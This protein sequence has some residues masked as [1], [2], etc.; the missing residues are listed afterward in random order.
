MHVLAMDN[1]P[2][3]LGKMA[4]QLALE[5]I[6]I[7]YVYGSAMDDAERSIFVFHVDENDWERA[8]TVFSD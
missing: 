3:I 8:S 6:N 1:R 5:N 4:R 7:D 2:G